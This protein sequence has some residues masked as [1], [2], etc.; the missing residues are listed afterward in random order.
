MP[1]E[2]KCDRCGCSAQYENKPATISKLGQK[3]GTIPVYADI[4]FP[5]CECDCHTAWRIFTNRKDQI[6]RTH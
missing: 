2:P 5:E 6:V 4:D 3:K 1:R